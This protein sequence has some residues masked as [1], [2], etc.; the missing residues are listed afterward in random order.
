MT[1]HQRSHVR[2]VLGFVLPLAALLLG[3]CFNPFDPLV[4]KNRVGASDP[5]PNPTR[6]DQIIRLFEWCWDHRSINDYEEVFTDDFLFAF[7]ST[8]SAGRA[9]QGAVLTR[10]DEIETARHLFVGGGTS[11]PANS[12]SLQLDQNLFALQDTRPGKKD[13]TY[14][15]E[16][17]TSVV[18]RIDTDEDN[19]QVTGDARFFVVRGDS[20][21]IPQDLQDRGF[22]PDKDRWYIERWEDET[23][24]SGGGIANAVARDRGRSGL[25]ARRPVTEGKPAAGQSRTQSGPLDV[26]WGFVKS[27]FYPRR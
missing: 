17:I 23:Q 15:R 4:A 13:T 27:V 21:L 5:P 20:A 24:G 3:G 8:D 6:P 10:T 25:S 2:S 22:R 19:F 11:P 16:I 9:F 18:L 12:V 1:R 14:H 7:A 26:T